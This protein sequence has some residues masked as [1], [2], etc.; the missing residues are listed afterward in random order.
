METIITKQIAED[1]MKAKGQVR[2]HSIKIDFDYVLEK[3]GEEGIKKLED[4]LESLGYPFL[5][6]EIK[7]MKFYPLGIQIIVVLA[8]AQLFGYDEKE[9]EKVGEFSSIMPFIIRLFMRYLV[10]IETVA[11]YAQR[12]W[13]THYDVGKIEVIEINKEKKYAVV[14]VEDFRTHPFH[15]IVTKA[16]IANVIKIAVKGSSV[17]HEETKCVFRNDDY[18]EFLVKWQ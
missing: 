13:R 7:L 9:F 17:S 16:Y 11:K 15:C 3:E 6:K 2:G 1:L 4:E 8:M 5:H 18:H 14:R 10:S 12:M